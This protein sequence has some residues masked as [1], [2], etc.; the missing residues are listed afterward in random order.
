MLIALI[1]SSILSAVLLLP[2]LS[3]TPLRADWKSRRGVIL[4][5]ILPLFLPGLFGRR[6]YAVV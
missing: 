3:I 6:G 4:P 5:V 1:C 2:S